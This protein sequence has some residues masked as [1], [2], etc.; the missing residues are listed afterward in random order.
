MPKEKPGRLNRE[1]NAD[2]TAYMLSFNEL[3]A[4]ETELSRDTQ[5]LKQIQIIATK[6]DRK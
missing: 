5:V 3:P 1:I 4:G 2:I 6:P